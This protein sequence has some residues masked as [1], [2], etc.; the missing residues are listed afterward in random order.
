MG[1]ETQGIIGGDE[2]R[3][4]LPGIAQENTESSLPSEASRQVLDLHLGLSF[5]KKGVAGWAENFLGFLPIPCV[6]VQGRR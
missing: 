5:W 1:R 2:S 4:E 3:S 6:E